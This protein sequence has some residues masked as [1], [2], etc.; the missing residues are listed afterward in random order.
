MTSVLTFSTS[1]GGARL[2][3]RLLLSPKWGEKTTSPDGGVSIVVV[4]TS[5][6]MI[7]I[8]RLNSEMDTF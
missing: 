3:L 1:L 6:T 4:G 7:L 8:N 2:D 5:D